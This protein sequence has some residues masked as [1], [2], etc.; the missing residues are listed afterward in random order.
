[1]SALQSHPAWQILLDKKTN[2]PYYYNRSAN[3]N[4]YTVPDDLLTPAQKATGWAQTTAD[5]G[6]VYFFR[7]DDKTKTSWT[8]PP[9]WETPAA[10]PVQEAPQFVSSSFQAHP[11]ARE[12]RG[13]RESRP[14]HDRREESNYRGP[15]AVAATGPEYASREEAEAAFTKL[16]RKSGV[17]PGWSWE[18]AMR[19]TIQD[20]QYRAIKEPSERKAAFEK[21]LDDVVREDQEREKE[22]IKKLR[23][24]FRSMLQTH[25]EIKHYT[26]W[27]TARPML[28]NEAIFRATDNEDE[29]RRLFDDYLID[30][31]KAAEDK[32]QRDYDAAMTGVADLL[33]VLDLNAKSQWME[34][35]ERLHSH[36]DF[37]EDPKYKILSPSEP[38][39]IF[40]RYMRRLWND[41]H[42]EKQRTAQLKAR[43]QRKAREGFAA[44]LAE[45]R[46]AE[47]I[48]PGTMWKEV[49]P[50]IE[51]EPRYIKLMDNL[52]HKDRIAD[53]STPQDIFF[54]F[55]DD[56][57]KEVHDIRP[58]VEATLKEEHFRFV[59][60]TT[61]E[62]F[63]H[64]IRQDRRI[65]S[66]NPH[67][68][69]EVYKR[70]HRNALD[71]EEDIERDAKRQQRKAVDALRSRIKHLEPPVLIGDTW[72][73]VRPRVERSEEYKA[74][75]SDE[76]RQ[77]AYD[78]FMNRLK[79]DAAERERL[80]R[81]DRERE[82][83]RDRRRDR[84]RRRSRSPPSREVDAYEADRRRAASERER[85]YRHSSISGLSPPPRE[86]PRVRDDRYERDVGDPR[87]ERQVS[88]S[89]YDRERREREAERERSYISRADPRTKASELDY[90][91]GGDSPK[92]E[93]TSGGNNSNKRSAAGNGDSDAKRQAKR[94]R[95]GEH[96]SSRNVTPAP[97]TAE[98]DEPALQSGSEEGEIEEV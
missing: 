3:I 80:R 39:Q 9:G 27:K 72:E 16:L 47:T 85:Q 12:Q 96:T 29:K 57:D 86:R 43:E 81:H 44:L 1:M 2:K 17:Q 79:E 20:P 54:D 24:D 59:P 23:S 60:S 28:E 22:R 64:A 48:K 73:Q 70:L 71:R 83:D 84:E 38:L 19:A 94:P 56:F 87:R 97:S 75:T 66:M 52:G 63:L 8:P 51:N 91:D 55:L 41:A 10:A 58:A 42:N 76:D 95:V 67:L 50:L 25:P 7:K 40:D 5:G 33:Q 15:I 49:Y 18:R 45:L 89:I 69:E 36:P 98:N 6:R 26:R 4:T 14:F 77:L 61:L 30:L 88:L 21:Y 32:R 93:S 62:E 82:R 90:G 78:K 74:V 46:E 11:P 34:T 37:Q 68:L 65:S 53:G 31:R 13:P 35:R 92:P